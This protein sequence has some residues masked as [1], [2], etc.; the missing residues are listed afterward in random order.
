M[1]RLMKNKKAKNRLKYCED[2]M[3]YDTI[4]YSFFTVGGGKG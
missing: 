4:E 3:I 2:R 1:E